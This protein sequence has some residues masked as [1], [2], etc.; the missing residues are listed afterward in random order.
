MPI[1]FR[2]P[3]GHRLGAPDHYAGKKIR[4]PVC[5][6]KVRIPRPNK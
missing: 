1:E 3:L 4:C 6:E 5:R 2:C